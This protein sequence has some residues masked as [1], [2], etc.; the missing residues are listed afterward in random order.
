MKLTPFVHYNMWHVIPTIAITYETKYYLSIDIAW[1]KW[2]ISI[3]I[4]DK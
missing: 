1:L 3:I 4:I 2:G